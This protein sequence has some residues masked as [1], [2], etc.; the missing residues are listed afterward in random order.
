[1]D[2]APL[3][4][5]DSF[6]SKFNKLNYKKGET[7]LR[8]GEDPKGVFYLKKG[9]VRLYSISKGG[10][11]LSLIIFMKGDLFP[12]TWAINGTPNSYFLEAITASEIRRAPNRDFLEFVNNNPDVYFDLTGKMLTR[13]GGVLRRMEY[14]VFGNA[15]SKIASII[16]ISAD[17]FGKK[18]GDLVVIEVPMTHNDIARLVGLSRETASI[19][20][21]KL[22]NKRLIG[23]RGRLIVV[24][25]YKKLTKESLV[26]PD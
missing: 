2:N 6:F 17:R 15:Y 16:L 12:I 20:I 1:M 26:E 22:E 9:F 8:A 18:I 13:L 11:E 24:K 23:Y 25:N 7:I 19:E 4:K 21:K 5:M 10:E 3:S 14:L